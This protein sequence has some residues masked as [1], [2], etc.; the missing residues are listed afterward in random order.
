MFI[1]GGTGGVAGSLMQIVYDLDHNHLVGQAAVTAD[2]WEAAVIVEPGRRSLVAGQTGAGINPSDFSQPRVFDIRPLPLTRVNV[3]FPDAITVK[4]AGGGREGATVVITVLSGPGGAAPGEARVVSGKWETSATNWPDGLYK[5]SAIQKISNNAGGWIE[6]TPI[7]FEVTYLFPLPSGVKSTPEYQTT[8]SGNG[9]LGATVSVLDSDKLTKIA[10]DAPVRN[11][12]TWSTTAYVPWGPTWD[13]TIYVHQ[14]IGSRKS[15]SVEHKVRIPPIAPGIGS[16]SP[17]GLSPTFT[18]TCEQDARV[19]LV[20]SDDATP[21][22]AV[23]TGR[24]WSFRRTLPFTPDV[25]HTVTATQIAAQQTSPAASRQFKQQRPMVTVVITHPAQNSE[26]GHG[27]VTFKGTGGMKGATVSVWDYVNGGTLGS[28]TLGADGPWEIVV[29]MTFGRRVVRAKQ[30][31]GDRESAYSALREFNV[32]LLQPEIDEPSEAGTQTRTSM[33]EGT[34]EPLGYVD[35]FKGSSTTPFLEKVPIGVNGRWKAEAIEPVGNK[36]IRARQY[37]Q[38]QI[39]K[40]TQPR[41]YKVVPHSPFM[42]TPA[43]GDHVGKRAMVSGFGVPGDKVKVKLGPGTDPALGEAFVGEDRTWS[44][45]VEI[46]RAGP[47]VSL[48]ATS[49][50]GTFESAA[51]APR[52][53]L[54]GIFEPTIQSPAEGRPVLNPVHFAG[55]GRDGEAQ[56]CSWYNPEVIQASVLPVTTATGWQG[57]ASIALSPGGNW[58]VIQQTLTK[59]QDGATVSDKVTS[60]RFEVEPVPSEGKLSDVPDKWSL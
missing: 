12:N 55:T 5:M 42:E 17:E 8:F 2:A 6:S 41:T 45:P 32:V 15:A 18:G 29:Q 57:A 54:A 20:F 60:H 3:T 25:E 14:F 38:S 51:S 43:A 10:P 11:D 16:V 47:A 22:P 27:D 50:E 1:L 53:V 7:E 36:T 48:V 4:F 35:V 34:G 9:L 39:S 46:P 26:V 33:I 13:R 40:D 49:S 23:V 59:D 28:V 21:Y 44:I 31:I 52:S 19:N 56:L 37:F 24:A 30:V 58:S